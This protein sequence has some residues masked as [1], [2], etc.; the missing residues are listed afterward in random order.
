MHCRD[1]HYIAGIVRAGTT[2]FGV[3]RKQVDMLRSLKLP[4]LV[5]WS[6]NDEFMEEE[7]PRELARL[8]HPG[9]RLAFAG[10]GHNVQKT[11]AEQVAGALT[12]WIEDVLT[13][14]TEGEQQSTQ[15][16]P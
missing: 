6:Q 5:A 7:I 14:D 16:L 2:D 11:R 15:S 8:C 10:G 12:R 3:I 1:T 4:S 9:P 13:E